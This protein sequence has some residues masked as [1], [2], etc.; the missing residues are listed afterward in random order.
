MYSYS[1]TPF[2]SIG[3]TH[4]LHGLPLQKTPPSFLYLPDDARPAPQSAD[5]GSGLGC[6]N[7][8]NGRVSVF[9]RIGER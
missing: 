5:T 8:A 9:V 3:V 6:A 7:L 1:I 2:S 4:M